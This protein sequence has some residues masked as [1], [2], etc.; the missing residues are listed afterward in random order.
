MPISI[1][2]ADDAQIVRKAIRALLEAEPEIEIVGEATNFSETIDL[3][4]RLK[5]GIVI[6]DLHMSDEDT[7]VRSDIKTC[8]ANGSR[9]LAISFA[10]ED[11][12]MA[13]ATSCGADI[14]LDKMNLGTELVPAIK[15]LAGPLDEKPPAINKPFCLVASKT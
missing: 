11:E 6:M 7:V 5:P 15:Q 2:I 14:L 3:T 13:L 1:L 12:T 4:T 9:L 10:I 8:F